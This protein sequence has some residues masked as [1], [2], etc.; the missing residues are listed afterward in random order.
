MLAQIV[1]MVTQAQRSRAPIQRLAD[2]VSAWFVPLVMAVAVVAFVAWAVWGPQPR[3]TLRSNRGGLRA[4]H[5]LSV[6]LGSCDADVHHGRPWAQ[7]AGHPHQ[8]R[9]SP[10]A[11][12]A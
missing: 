8:E 7:R 2:Q 11:L 9:R 6:C 1:R 12:R 10:R 3:L 5:R 4:H